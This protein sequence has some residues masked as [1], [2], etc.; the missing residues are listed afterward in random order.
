LNLLKN[1][2]SIRKSSKNNERLTIKKKLTLYKISNFR[3]VALLTSY[4]DYLVFSINQ[5]D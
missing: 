2:K 1:V 4:E 3:S 5:A